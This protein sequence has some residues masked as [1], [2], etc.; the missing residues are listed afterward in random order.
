MTG[1]GNTRAAAK[2]IHNLGWVYAHTGRLDTAVEYYTRALGT[3]SAIGDR[4][5]EMTVHYS[6]AEARANMGELEAALEHI[7]PAIDMAET[8]RASITATQLRT[9]YFASVQDR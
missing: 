1:L 2:P 4:I 9:A 7:R 3:L 6:F 5:G 8:L